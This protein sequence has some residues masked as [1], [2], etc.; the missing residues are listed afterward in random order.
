MLSCTNQQE[1]KKDVQ[2]RN[3]RLNVI[4]DSVSIDSAQIDTSF[5]YQINLKNDTFF[6]R[7]LNGIVQV[8]ILTDSIISLVITYKNIRITQS[9]SRFIRTSYPCFYDTSEKADMY[10]SIVNKPTENKFG[11]DKSRELN[12]VAL[13]SWGCDIWNCDYI[14]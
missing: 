7:Q 3:V 4:V 5:C 10:L 13:W 14:E 1:K 6:L 9:D 11:F 8:P 12:W 2:Y